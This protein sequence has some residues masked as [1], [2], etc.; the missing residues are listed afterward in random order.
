MIGRKRRSTC[1]SARHGCLRVTCTAHWTRPSLRRHTR[2]RSASTTSSPSTRS[3][4]HTVLTWRHVTWPQNQ[5]YTMHWRSSLPACPIANAHGQC[6]INANRGP[7][8]FSAHLDSPGKG[9]LNRCAVRP[10]AIICPSP[11]TCETKTYHSQPVESIRHAGNYFVPISIR[12]IFIFLLQ[13]LC[14]ITWLL[15]GWKNV[16]TSGG[17][18]RPNA[19][20][21]CHICHMVNPALHMG[22]VNKS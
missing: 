2:R 13:K 22:E 17:P 12:P 18:L 3:G 16:S 11:L 1:S 9:P 19:R 21:I 20:G 15:T 7:C 5:S 14:Q 6:R 4:R 8:A 10:V